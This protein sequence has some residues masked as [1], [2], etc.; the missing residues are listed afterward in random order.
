M[1]RNVFDVTKIHSANLVNLKQYSTVP[2]LNCALCLANW[3]FRLRLSPVMLS[4]TVQKFQVTKWEKTEYG[5]FYNGDS[6]I[7]LNVCSLTTL[8]IYV[9]KYSIHTYKKFTREAD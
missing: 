9:F 3:H 1:A 5:K 2:W 7:L 6:Y 8:F 4:W